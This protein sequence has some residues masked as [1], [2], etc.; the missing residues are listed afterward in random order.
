MNMSAWA[1]RNPV[2]VILL[3]LVLTALG[4]FS[5]TTLPITY[6]PTIDVP[7]VGVTITQ[8]AAA[9]DQL[10][11]Q[12]TEIVEGAVVA[13]PG[14]KHIESTISEGRSV[15]T[16]EFEIGVPTDRAVSDVR[17]AVARI[18]DD[19]PALID[20]PSIERIESENRPIVVYSV[21][22]SAM[23]PSQLSI[24]VEDVVVRKIQGVPGVGRVELVGNVER[25]VQLRLDPDR[26]DALALTAAAVSEQIAVSQSDL[27]AGR[28]T[29]N[30]Q[31]RMLATKS[32]VASLKELA[33]IRLNLP[34][35][36]T[37]AVS[38]VATIQDT[39]KKRETFAHL[40]GS[41][42]IGFTV[43]KAL[44]AGDVAVADKVANALVEVNARHPS[45]QFAIVDDSVTR[46]LGNYHSA[47]TTLVEGAILAIIVVFVFLRDWRATVIA[48]ISLPLSILPTFW[49][50]A[51][52]GFSLNMLSLLAI[53]LV[54]G[55]LVDDS[56]VEIE[57]IVRHR[58]MGKSPY[59]ASMDAS[60][61]IGLAVIAIS[62]A[63]I[64]VFAPVGFMPGETGQ[65]FRQFG[66]TV[67]VA[68]FFSLLVARMVTP[69]M[70][71]YFMGRAPHTSHEGP[72]TREYRRLLGVILEWR[73]AILM[74]S[75]ALFAASLSLVPFLPTEFLPGE[76]TGR[77]SVS[78]ELPPGSTLDSNERTS[79]VIAERL[80]AIPQVRT[81]FVQGGSGSGGPPEVRRS[82]AVISLVAADD[83]TESTADLE[84]VISR[85]L[86]TVPDIRFELLTDRG[87]RAISFALLSPQGE[88]A[89]KAAS[90]IVREMKASDVFVNPVSSEATHQPTVELQVSADKAADLG[91]TA[92]QIAEAIRVST[93]GAPDKTLAN[94][95]DQGR[96]V[97]IRALLDDRALASLED[98]EQVRVKTQNGAMVTLASVVAV[99]TGDSVSII[100]RLERE[101]QIEIGSDLRVG[102]DQ[103]RGMASIMAL[104]SVKALPPTVR[105]QATG[106][107]DTM[108]SVF[109]S[110]AFAMTAGLTLVLMVLV[111]LFGNP[112][113]PVTIATP[114]PLAVTGV[115][116]AVYATGYALSLPVVIGILMLMGI[117]VKNS[118]MLVDFAIALER[119]GLSCRA[120]TIEACA[121]RI[122][123]IAMTTLAM[124][125]GMIPAAI[126]HEAGGEFRAPMAVAVIGG[127]AVSTILSLIVVPAI[128]ILIA[129]LESR[130][131]G[132]AKSHQGAGPAPI[133]NIFGKEP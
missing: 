5:Y 122:R 104:A 72:V 33:A 133:A 55:I 76:D 52:M 20:E 83:R 79:E 115:I 109:T 68:V 45:A 34:D 38:D 74:A 16:V 50:I 26:L 116:G 48:A 88:L 75:A 21:G 65:Y 2:P 60:S 103:G 99:K 58:N 129:D 80:K 127:L 17:D 78:I 44:T 66:L 10:E 64:S 123:P 125:A 11:L 12:A 31:D 6:F 84:K 113:T 87:G 29:V 23:T 96:L 126:G 73:R 70:A 9:P 71:A 82:T 93:L 89:S 130:I 69:L 90:D 53:T 51:M 57:N 102:I 119:T 40:D 47:Q 112:L 100:Q 37:V 95:N 110:F 30:L 98:L 7:M 54:T 41:P 118:I 43:Y 19:L 120:A 28:G 42:V 132:S 121:E 107:S 124:I 3:F 1:I 27:P 86:S 13:I 4:I 18:R 77:V 97:P 61:E 39:I 46:T 108:D 63:I 106:D 81:V 67:A 131:R 15:T 114:L 32:A 56:I 94:F 24:F 105:L 36:K 22:D 91:V 49:V 117:V 101:R 111:L 92:T 14:I 85:V 62:A 8:S 35:G 59:D 25:E 128:H